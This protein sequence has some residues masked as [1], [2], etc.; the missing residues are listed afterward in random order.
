M[1]QGQWQACNKLQSHLKAA[2]TSNAC[3]DCS[4]RLHGK[5][6]SGWWPQQLMQAGLLLQVDAEQL[7]LPASRRQQRPWVWW[8][9]GWWLGV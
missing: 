6:G 9:V 2:P 7:N 4:G 3:T 5:M 1:R 8:R